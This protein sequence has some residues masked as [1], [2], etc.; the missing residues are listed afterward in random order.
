MGFM[1]LHVYRQRPIRLIQSRRRRAGVARRKKRAR[2]GEAALNASCYKAT[3]DVSLAFSQYNRSTLTVDVFPILKPNPELT[4]WFW[5]KTR[6]KVTEIGNFIQLILRSCFLHFLIETLPFWTAKKYFRRCR[7]TQ[8]PLVQIPR[9]LCLL[10]ENRKQ[11]STE[12]VK[13]LAHLRQCV[14]LDKIYKAVTN[15]RSAVI[16]K[17]INSWPR[18]KY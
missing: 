7:H 17:L 11:K 12:I 15:E 14:K 9:G 3:A 8:E 13:C 6:V 10:I 1:T 18:N 2:L 4:A 16:A 5:S